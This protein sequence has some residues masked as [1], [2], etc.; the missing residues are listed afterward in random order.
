[1]ARFELL[2]STPLPPHLAWA[3]LWDL[4]AHDRLIPLTR[5]RGDALDAPGAVAAAL[6]PG[7][8][9][10]ARTQLPGA[11]AIG[12][13]DPMEVVTWRP[14]GTDGRGAARLRKLGPVIRGHIEAEVA[15][16]GPGAA[17]TW[18]QEI[19]V[20]GV[21]RGADMLTAAVARAAYGRVLRR[22]LAG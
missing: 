13:D 17:V 5:L 20:A 7:S 10:V 9:F 1:M 2:L 15:P 16:Q 12:F 21:P 8:R 4:R 3:A 14:P 6:H 19:G 11:P 22:L 18:R